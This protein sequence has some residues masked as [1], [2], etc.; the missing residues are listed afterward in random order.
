VEFETVLLEK[1]D[2]GIGVLTFNRPEVL[3]AH[4]YKMR[5][6]VQAA[7]EAAKADDEIRVLIVTGA[8]RA[9]HAGDDAKDRLQGGLEQLQKDRQAAAVGLLD[10]DVWTGQLNPRYF[11]GYP[12]PTIAA[13]NGAAVGA[14]MS[15]AISCDIRIAS[16]NAKFGYFFT[17]RGVMGP[18]HGLIVLVHSIG[19]SRT[20]E[21]ML[22]GELVDAVEADRIGL[23]SRVVPA[24]QLLDEAKITARK[25]M[26]GAPLA[27]RAIKETLYRALFP[28]DGLE[29]FNI[30]MDTAL[31]ATEDHHEGFLAFNERREP[32]WRS[33]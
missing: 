10:K 17:R 2:D 29:D 20:M 4:N 3:N 8:G 15:I 19:V 1:D 27:Q 11:Y 5:Q 13:V 25:L 9:F 6:E 30:R 21:M 31:T 14:G 7:C 23:V 18:S 33:R 16:E 28:A 32:V 24:D 22:S 12:K 26:V